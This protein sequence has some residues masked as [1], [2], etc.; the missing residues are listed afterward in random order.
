MFY[1]EEENEILSERYETNI[2]SFEEACFRGKIARRKPNL[3]NKEIPLSLVLETHLKLSVFGRFMHQFN[4][5][6]FKSCMVNE[7]KLLLEK[8]DMK[9]FAKKDKRDWDFWH[10]FSENLFELL[11]KSIEERRHVDLEYFQ[12]TLEILRLNDGIVKCYIIRVHNYY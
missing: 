8:Y 1:S 10:S 3:I 11:E 6:Q 7:N 12:E 4:P 9:C 2:W 5:D